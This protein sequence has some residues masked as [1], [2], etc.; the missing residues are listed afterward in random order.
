MLLNDIKIRE[1]ATQ[2]MIRP[3]EPSLIREVQDSLIQNAPLRKVISFGLSSYGYDLR[4]LPSVFKIFRKIPGEVVDPKDFA[5]EFLEDAELH[6][7]RKGKFFILPAHSYGL[8]VAMER[9]EIPRNIT[10]LFIGKSTYARCGVIA[11]LTPGEA[12]WRGNLTIE[13]SNSSDADCRIYANEGIVQALFLEG[14][15]CETSYADRG[16]KYQDQGEVVTLAKC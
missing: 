15:P 4:L 5:P 8:G 14:Y 7:D 1:L 11:N 10:C 2:G 3:F 6:R 9:L 12:G 13:I 16:G